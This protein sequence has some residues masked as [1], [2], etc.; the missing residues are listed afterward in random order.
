MTGNVRLS[1][2]LLPVVVAGLGAVQILFPHRAWAT[3]L[4]ALGGAWLI[5]WFWARALARGLTLVRER[6]FG[7]SQVGDQLEER[8]TVINRD[9]PP[10]LWFEVLDESTLPGYE[11]SR[12]MGVEGNSQVQWTTQGACERRGAFRLGPTRLRTGDPFGIYTVELRHPATTPVFVTPPI[13]PLPAVEVAPGGRAGEGRPQRRALERTVAAAAVRQYVPGDPLRWIHWPTSAR[14]NSL[15]VRLPENTPA[16][17]WWIFLDLDRT[18]Q[19]G[20]GAQATEEHAIMLA[21][22]LA[23]LGLGE[24][25]AVGLVAFGDSLLRLAPKA[26]EGQRVEIL[27]ALAL[28]RPG[29]V[30]LG[31]LLTRARPPLRELASVILITPNVS[32]AWIEALMPLVWRGAAPTA[33]VLDPTTYGGRDGPQ[34]VLTALANAQVRRFVITREL[35]DRP[36]AHPGQRGLHWRISPSGRAILTTRAEELVWKAS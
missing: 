10:A 6:R 3:L 22:S 25:H 15:Y 2:R 1:S 27:R 9:W 16:G 24:G 12:A 5:A 30:S 36:E 7:L 17:D 33:F 28:A 23:N 32:P 34:S 29:P 14:H 31:E 19:A 11:V 20:E 13:L 18:V 4:V 35:L 8:F 26:G 21:A